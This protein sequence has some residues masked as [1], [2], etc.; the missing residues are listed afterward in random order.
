MAAEKKR[1]LR[2]QPNKKRNCLNTSYG[3]LTFTC[4]G[5]NGCG[6]RYGCAA[7]GVKVRT[8]KSC[9]NNSQKHFLSS[10]LV[11]AFGFLPILLA[12]ARAALCLLRPLGQRLFHHAWAMPVR[13]MAPSYFTR[14]GSV[15]FLL[16]PPFLT[17]MRPPT[18]S[19]A[20]NSGATVEMLPS[21]SRSLQLQLS[22]SCS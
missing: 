7:E 22:K 19:F 9:A 2:P 3:G 16:Q 15:S 1:R 8:P 17:K 10:C 13:L 12:G 20:G 14:D 6:Q 21:S 11:C 4:L 18:T 5:Q